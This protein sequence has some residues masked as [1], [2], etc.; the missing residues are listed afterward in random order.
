MKFYYNKKVFL[1]A[2]WFQWIM[3]EFIGYNE[4]DLVEKQWI[5]WSNE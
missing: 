1:Y 4:W 2:D 5:H 3:S